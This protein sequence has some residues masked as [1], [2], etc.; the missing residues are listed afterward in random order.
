M[1]RYS[2]ASTSL[3]AGC[4]VLF[5]LACAC[6]G[7]SSNIVESPDTTDRTTTVAPANTVVAT[8][9]PEAPAATEQ[10]DLLFFSD[11]LGWSVAHQW[12][13]RIEAELGVEVTVH[14]YATGNL[15]AV[16]IDQWLAPGGLHR[17]LLAEAEIISFFGNPRGSGVVADSETCISPSTIPREP[18]AEYSSADWDG[19][20]KV[21]RSIY[22]S[23]FEARAGEPTVVRAMDFMLSVVAEWK[24]AGIYDECLRELTL[25]NE[26]IAEVAAEYGV[27]V[28]SVF[29]AF[30][31]VNHDEDPKEKGWIGSDR[32]HTNA[33]G[34][35]AMVEVFHGL[36]YDPLR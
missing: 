9:T 19:Y 24:E 22:E 33:E 35:A 11:S 32:I 6:G 16:K 15:S 2:Q 3:V 4:C 8:T 10:W 20:K 31:G 7:E 12:A 1:P 26:V 34:Q 28:A 17:Q 29:S 5:L 18:P 14:D 27:P 25:M 21:L 13:A 36:G 30:N 23:I